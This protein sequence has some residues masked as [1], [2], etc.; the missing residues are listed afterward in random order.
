VK[1]E[2]VSGNVWN[3]SLVHAANPDRARLYAD[4]LTS[5]LGRPPAFSIDLAPVVG[6]HNGPGAVAVALMKE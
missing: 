6:V 3:Y 2:A 1:R 5:L 4:R